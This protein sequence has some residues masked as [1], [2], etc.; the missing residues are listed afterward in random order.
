MWLGT[1]DDI[2]DFHNAVLQIFGMADKLSKGVNWKLPDR[3][4]NSRITPR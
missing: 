4:G 1:L 2:S 3:F